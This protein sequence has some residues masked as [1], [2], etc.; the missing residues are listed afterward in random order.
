MSENLLCKICY[1][2]ALCFTVLSFA[3]GHH[4]F[5][6][7]V[8][9]RICLFVCLVV[10]DALI[11]GSFELPGLRFTEKFETWCSYWDLD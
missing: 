5:G 1:Y 6:V 2:A 4:L 7:L 10:G 9:V 11:M 3:E 8:F